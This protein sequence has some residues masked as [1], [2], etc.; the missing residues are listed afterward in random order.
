MR[1]IQI[2]DTHL[3]GPEDSLSSD[4]DPWQKL[5]TILDALL[6]EDID[7]LIHTGD[8]CLDQPHEDIYRKYQNRIAAFQ[9]P[10]I[11]VPGNHD[12]ASMMKDILSI[13]HTSFHMSQ[14]EGYTLLFLNTANGLV[15]TED[16]QRLRGLVD[17]SDKPLL[18]FMHHPPLY[19]GSMHMDRNY[20]LQ[21]IE[22]V[23]PVIRGS[24]VPIE[25]FCGHYHMN[26]SIKVNN[27]QVHIT[28]SPFF[29]IDAAFFE[30]KKDFTAPAVYRW[31]RL[32]QGEM[33][34]GLS[35]IGG[36]NE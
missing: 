6:Q 31:I 13:A 17:T 3:T 11:H 5:Q 2:T 19:A 1:I 10:V 26:R 28:P 33:R 22:E 35:F 18:I 36:D 9:C 23:W 14:H 4:I 27:V 7:L 25:I 24:K 15:Q 16:L 30:M 34:Q 20:P 8:I 21:N 32:R 12:D 29:N